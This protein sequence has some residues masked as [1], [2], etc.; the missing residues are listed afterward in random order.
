MLVNN[1]VSYY[2]FSPVCRHKNHVSSALMKNENEFKTIII[3]Y[4]VSL[5]DACMYGN[6]VVSLGNHNFFWIPTC[7]K[8]LK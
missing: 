7:C 4:I 1:N 8:I 6:T 3:E 5:P 2:S